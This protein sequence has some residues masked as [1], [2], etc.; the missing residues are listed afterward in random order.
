MQ[1]MSKMNQNNVQFK[2]ARQREFEAK[3]CRHYRAIGIPAVIAATALKS[4]KRIALSNDK[5]PKK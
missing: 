3:F 5:S 1:G 4:E 2:S